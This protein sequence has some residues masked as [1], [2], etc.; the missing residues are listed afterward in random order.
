MKKSR[1]TTYEGV[2]IYPPYHESLLFSEKRG[3]LSEIGEPRLLILERFPGTHAY[4]P[5]IFYEHSTIN[6]N[7]PGTPEWYKLVD[8]IGYTLD[9]LLLTAIERG[10]SGVIYNEVSPQGASLAMNKGNRV[11]QRLK[12]AN[13]DD[14]CV[15]AENESFEIGLN[16]L[17]KRGRIEY[18]KLI[19]KINSFL[20]W[21]GGIK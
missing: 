2:E 6:P 19:R 8:R 15:N 14:R 11:A 1:F 13:L 4:I 16:K 21:R 12:D 18:N 20:L 3:R 5:R 10:I 9:Y 17:E 7:I